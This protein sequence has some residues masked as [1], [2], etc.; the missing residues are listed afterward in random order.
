MTRTVW[1]DMG[2]STIVICTFPGIG[3]QVG[4]GGGGDGYCS[5]PKILANSYFLGSKTRQDILDL[6][7][8][9]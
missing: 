6:L 3:V 8:G 5:L 9:T 1:F 4:G 2:V 7:A